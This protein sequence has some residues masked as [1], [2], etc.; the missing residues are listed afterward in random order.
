MVLSVVQAEGQITRKKAAELCQVSE[1]QA[2]RL[3]RKLCEESQLKLFGKGRGAH[4][5]ARNAR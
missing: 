1:D 2:S 4:Y 3:L 5:V